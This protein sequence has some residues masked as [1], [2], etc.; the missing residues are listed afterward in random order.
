MAPPGQGNYDGP[1]DAYG[2]GTRIPAL[3]IGKPV[4]RSTVD[5]TSYDT[6]SILRTI[7]ERWGLAALATRDGDATGLLDDAIGDA[8]A[9]R[10]ED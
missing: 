7:E 2:P 6:T 10:P 1:H 5:H 9:T 3:L 4:A 8:P